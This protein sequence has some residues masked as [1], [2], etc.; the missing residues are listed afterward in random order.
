MSP[1][2]YDKISLVLGRY[3]TL[4]VSHLNKVFLVV[5]DD[6]HLVKH[7]NKVLA[8]NDHDFLLNLRDNPYRAYRVIRDMYSLL[9]NW[10][11]VDVLRNEDKD[12]YFQLLRDGVTHK[13]KADTTALLYIE[14]LI[15]Q[16]S[17]LIEDENRYQQFTDTKPL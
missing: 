4:T 1:S 3:L 13:F 7:K 9:Q 16:I 2:L 17:E 8:R 15:A 10:G 12:F 5:N 14:L 11:R 6:L